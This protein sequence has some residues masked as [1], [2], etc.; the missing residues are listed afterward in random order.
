MTQDENSVNM[1]T[2]YFTEYNRTT[3]SRTSEVFYLY[4]LEDLQSSPADEYAIVVSKNRR[5][6]EILE[7]GT[8]TIE[9][10]ELQISAVNDELQAVNEEPLSEEECEVLQDEYQQMTKEVIRDRLYEGQLQLYKN[11]A[12]TRL[13]DMGMA[14]KNRSKSRPVLNSLSEDYQEEI[15]YA[16]ERSLDWEQTQVPIRKDTYFNSYK[17]VPDDIQDIPYSENCQL[18]AVL[19]FDEFPEWKINAIEYRHNSIIKN[20]RRAKVQSLLDYGYSREEIAQTLGISYDTVVQECKMLE[21]IYRQVQW[22]KEN[23]NV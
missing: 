21:E 16:V 12:F 17:I 9:P 3:I 22:T 11:L 1:D 15:G 14:M 18:K 2:K 19:K 13:P 7:M 4:A 5:T 10:A 8:M 6:P 23:M 20:G